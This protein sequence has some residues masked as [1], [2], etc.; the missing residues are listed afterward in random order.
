MCQGF[1]Y[2]SVIIKNI[3]FQLNFLANNEII[4]YDNKIKIVWKKITRM[5]FVF[6]NNLKFSAVKKN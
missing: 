1:P 4:K 3:M 6:P 5:F 2:E